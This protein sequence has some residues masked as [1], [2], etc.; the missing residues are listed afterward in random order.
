MNM[1][2]N[3]AILV[4]IELKIAGNQR[5]RRNVCFMHESLGCSYVVCY[6]LVHLWEAVIYW[7]CL[8]FLL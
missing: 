1:Q 2:K 7:T 5:N 3:T 6:G 8:W 4:L